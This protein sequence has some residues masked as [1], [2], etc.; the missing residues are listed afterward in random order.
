MEGLPENIDS[1]RRRLRLVVIAVVLLTIVLLAA[2]L[3]G[4]IRIAFRPLLARYY[5]Q[6]IRIAPSALCVSALVR[7]SGEARL[8]FYQRAQ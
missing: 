6:A 7:K 2:I 4:S 5:S 3:Y 8:I 1:S